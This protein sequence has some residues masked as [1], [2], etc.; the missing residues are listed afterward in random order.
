MSILITRPAVEAIEAAIEAACADALEYGG[1][2]LA[3]DGEQPLVA[4]ALP[5]GPAARQGAT[6]LTTDAAFQNQAIAAVRTHVPALAYVG[7]WH[8]HPMW[9]PN[10]S[11]TDRATARAILTEDDATTSR[12]VLVLGT[13]RPDGQTSVHG[14][15][16][17]LDDDGE[18]Q[19]EEQPLVIVDHDDSE[20][21][22]R[23]GT[24]L[25]P[26]DR[27][28]LESPTPAP[29]STRPADLARI[30]VDLDDLTTEVPDLTFVLRTHDDVIGALLR[31]RDDEVV[32]FFPPEYPLGAPR[33]FAGALDGGPLR[34][35]ALPYGW[36]SQ[37]RLAEPVL[38]ALR[39]ARWQTT[40]PVALVHRCGRW[41]R[42]RLTLSPGGR[43]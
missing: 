20:V 1:S 26:L 18:L 16:A 22:R 29:A 38:A 17:E 5:T 34:P 39:A 36:S 32:L 40:G 37:H 3:L 27:L 30:C 35:I 10:L 14:F 24:T 42:A 23:L 43:P 9:L 4:Y 33:V 19:V 21:V 28:L 25:P 13:R 2:L 15:T 12:L 11:A 8:I 7:D 31:R 41:L 6:H